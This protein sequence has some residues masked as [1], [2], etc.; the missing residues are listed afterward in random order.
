[1]YNWKTETFSLMY[2]LLYAT[3]IVQIN[4]WCSIPWKHYLIIDFRIW[5][6]AFYVRSFS[7]LFFCFMRLLT[8]CNTYHRMHRVKLSWLTIRPQGKWIS[9]VCARVFIDGFQLNF[10]HYSHINGDCKLFYFVNSNH[11]NNNN[12]NNL[13]MN[14]FELFYSFKVFVCLFV[15]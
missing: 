10:N 13:D 5:T 15:Y 6:Y 12:N 9:H 3:E 7:L 14:T 4:E 8:K 11:N 2:M 1:M